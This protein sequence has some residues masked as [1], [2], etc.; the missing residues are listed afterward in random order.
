MTDYW[1]VSGE[2]AVVWITRLLWYHLH[3][4]GCSQRELEKPAP[5]LLRFPGA[6]PAELTRS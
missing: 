6:R 4:G 1:S 2:L 5:P 3:H